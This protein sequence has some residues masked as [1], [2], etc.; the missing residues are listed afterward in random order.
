LSGGGERCPQALAGQ[1]EKEDVKKEKSN[2][3]DDQ[4]A[5]SILYSTR[6]TTEKRGHI[7][8]LTSIS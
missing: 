7:Y 6:N 2:V 1:E 3:L 5:L 8:L 4:N